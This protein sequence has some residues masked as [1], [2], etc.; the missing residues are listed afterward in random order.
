MNFSCVELRTG[1][2]VGAQI[3]ASLCVSLM[4]TYLLTSVVLHAN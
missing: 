4:P 3:F 1:L 2:F